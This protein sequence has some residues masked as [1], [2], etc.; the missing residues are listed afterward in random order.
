[1]AVSRQKKQETI[2]QLKGLIADA[3]LVVVTHNKGLTVDDV[4]DLRRKARKAGAAY[5]VAKNTLT[6]LAIKESKFE[7]L[8]S[9]LS[10]PT[11][12]TASKDPVAAAKVVV[13]FANNNEKIE[14][15]GGF[16][17]GQVL[18]AAAVKNLA[19]LPS[20]DELRGKIVGLLQ[21]PAA[22]LASLAQAPAGQLAR[23]IGAYANKQ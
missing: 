5:K 4:S 8:D 11:A 1:M 3:E 22:K 20:L 10:G 17:Q 7:S 2:E 23:V 21:A 19:T 16:L 9:M 14:V 18:T 15:I 6:K 13:E 12:L